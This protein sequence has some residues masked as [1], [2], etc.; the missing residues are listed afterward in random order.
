MRESLQSEREGDQMKLTLD[1]KSD[2]PLYRQVAEQIRELV[3]GGALPPAARLPTVR[4]LASELGLTRLTIQSAYAELQS[5]GLVEAVVGRGTFV[6]QHLPHPQATAP[7]RIQAPPRTAQPPSSW[8]V[9]GILAELM[10]LN[11]RADLISFAGA[12]PAPET[13]PLRELKRALVASLD[14]PTAMSYGPVQGEAVL[15][16]QVSRLLLD[17][18][19]AA[20]PDTVLITAGAQQATAVTLGALALAGDVVLVEEPT[21]PGVIDLAAQ[22]G[23]R[24][25]GI[26]RDAEGLVPEALEA[27]CATY[28]PRLLYSVPTFHNPTGTTMSAERRAAL[29]RITAAHDVL[30]VEDDVYGFLGYDGTAPLP[31]RADDHG[32]HVIYITSFSKVLL[33]G[34]R[35]GA[36]V[37]SPKHLPALT[38]AKHNIDL[39]CSPALQRA[40]ADYLRRGAFGAHVHRARALYRA[41]R[42]ALI[43]SLERHVPMC[44]W[45]QPHGG[46]NLWVTLPEA[47]A[48]RDLFFEALEHGVGFARGQ[49]FFPQPR[50]SGSGHLRLSFGALSPEQIA[51]GV[52]RL[53]AALHAQQ[54]RRLDATARATRESAPFV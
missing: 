4:A 6:A 7:S 53:A 46:L 29:L 41:R 52:R 50:A 36:L 34:L 27:A 16:E 5:Q 11:E 3:R 51:E 22:R 24:V 9:Q 47:V 13:Y 54:Q 19:L 20:S 18:G 23:Q 30:V 12:F 25:V 45:T 21:Y 28:R 33:P 38:R 32:E 31:L 37:A 40:L 10:Q 26:P 42:D 1:R 39:L 14:D 48:E 15:R 17:R 43:E 44:T 35:L 49:A 2:V 8:L